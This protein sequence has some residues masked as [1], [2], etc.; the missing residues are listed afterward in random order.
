MPSL[1]EHARRAHR[2]GRD[3]AVRRRQRRER[4]AAVE[5]PDRHQVEE[6]DPG[7]GVRDG[8]VHRAAAEERAPTPRR[9]PRPSPHSGPAR[10]MR[11]SSR[12]AGRTLLQAHQ[13]AEPGNEHR[14][15]GGDAVAAQRRHVSHLVDVDA[16]HEADARTTAPERPVEARPT[17]TSR[18]ACSALVRPRSSSLPLLRSATTRNLNFQSIRPSGPRPASHFQR[19]ELGSGGAGPT[20]VAS[21]WFESAS[22]RWVIAA[23]WREPGGRRSSDRSPCGQRIRGDLAAAAAASARAASVFQR[24]RR[25]RDDGRPG[26][27]AAS[28]AT[29][30]PQPAQ[31]RSRVIGGRTRSVMTPAG[32]LAAAAAPIAHADR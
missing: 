14:R 20:P 23:C 5:L 1:R 21:T 6:V 25:G 15:A 18:A 12:G 28:A 11:A 8:A 26:T 27:R 31:V 19:P 7:A 9:A 17:R 32:A 16:D 2:G 10:P 22:T 30:V 24:L 3:P 29:S 13:G 4:A